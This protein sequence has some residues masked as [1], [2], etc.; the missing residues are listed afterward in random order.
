MGSEWRGK[1]EIQP[2]ERESDAG[3]GAEELGRACGLAFEVD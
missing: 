1:G 3:R 2:N